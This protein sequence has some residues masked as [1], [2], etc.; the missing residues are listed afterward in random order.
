MHSFNF[1]LFS[2]FLDQFTR[3]LKTRGTY[4]GKHEIMVESRDDRIKDYAC[5]EGFQFVL[6]I[7]W[8]KMDPVRVSYYD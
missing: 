2:G 7:T 6:A 5:N 1:G 8:D 4:M 3:L